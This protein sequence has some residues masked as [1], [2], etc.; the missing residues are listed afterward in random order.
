MKPRRVIVS[1]NWSS[2]YG[3]AGEVIQTSPHLMVRLDGDKFP[4][5]FGE[6]EVSPEPESSSV[7]MTGAE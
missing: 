5:R 3:M 2:F 1:A 7:N 6:R 4:M